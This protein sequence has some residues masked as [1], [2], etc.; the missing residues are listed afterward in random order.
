MKENNLKYV[1]GKDGK[2]S[3]YQTDITLNYKRIR[4]YAGRTKEEARAYLS[5]LILA[6][7]AGK[8]EELLNPKK[9]C[10]AFGEYGK[11]L[12]ESAE[13]KTTILAYSSTVYG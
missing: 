6:N 3:Y 10:D 1:K 13:W 9:T 7:K 2:P 8:L 5:K 4:R 11:A 12:L